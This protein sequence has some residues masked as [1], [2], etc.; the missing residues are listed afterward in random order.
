MACKW[1]CLRKF[2]LCLVLSYLKSV[3]FNLLYVP[4]FFFFW[5]GDASS[6]LPLFQTVFFLILTFYFDLYC[7]L[8]WKL[9]SNESRKPLELAARVNGHCSNT[10]F[11]QNHDTARPHYTFA[12]SFLQVRRG[13]KFTQTFKEKPLHHAHSEWKFT[14]TFKEKFSHHVDSK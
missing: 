6:P 10:K 2:A 12:V 13:W 14:R 3:L 9:R 8:V 1:G 4:I 11:F 5:G 7:L